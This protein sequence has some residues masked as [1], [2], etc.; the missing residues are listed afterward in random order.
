[1]KVRVWWWFLSETLLNQKFLGEKFG[2]FSQFHSLELYVNWLLPGLN[3]L[4]S[5]CYNQFGIILI[6]YSL[7][8]AAF[9]FWFTAWKREKQYSQI[10]ENDQ[11]NLEKR[12]FKNFLFTL[13]SLHRFSYFICHNITGLIAFIIISF[14]RLRT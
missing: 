13:F 5:H 4:S 9:D 14:T 11:I 12:L 1:M 6:T 8:N 3:K 7:A 10:T 2:N